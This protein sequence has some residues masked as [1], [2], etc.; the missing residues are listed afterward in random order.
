MWSV[1]EHPDFLR[2]R[3]ELPE[4]VSDKLDEVLLALAQAG[5]QLGRPMVDTLNGSKHANMKEIRVA[6]GGAWRFA[7]AFDTERN[8]VVLCGANKEG[9]ATRRF[10]KVL[11][12]RADKR[13]DDWLASEED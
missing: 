13:F 12:R 3:A 11:I 6:V 8:A 1:L 10:H 9:V 2:E 5:P 7:F 4:A